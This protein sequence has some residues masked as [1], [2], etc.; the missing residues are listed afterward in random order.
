MDRQAGKV[1]SLGCRGQGSEVVGPGGGSVQGK[2]AL[3]TCYLTVAS[4]SLVP[5]LIAL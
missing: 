2:L 3:A 4:I 1:V 5:L